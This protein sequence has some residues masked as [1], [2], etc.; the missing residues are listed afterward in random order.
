[1]VF[2]WVSHHFFSLNSL[3]LIIAYTPA[4]LRLRCVSAS[5]GY[6]LG[7]PL[8]SASFGGHAGGQIRKKIKI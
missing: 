7:F 1:M 2:I 3:P 5:P 8:R 6:G 4:R